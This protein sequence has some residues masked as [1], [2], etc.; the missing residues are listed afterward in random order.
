M[1]FRTTIPAPAIKPIIDVAVKNASISALSGQDTDE[2][3]RYCRHDCKRCFERLEPADDENV[4]KDH[5]QGRKGDT[6]IAK[7]LVRDV[8]FAVPL[9]RI[10][11]GQE[12]LRCDIAFEC[13]ALRQL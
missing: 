9:H 4:D 2:R 8:P 13:I 3:K 5:H 1:E 7:D 12:W 10:L 11:V 6:H